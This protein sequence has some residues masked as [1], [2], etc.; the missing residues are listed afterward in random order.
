[1]LDLSSL[2]KALAAFRAALEFFDGVGRNSAEEEREL[3]RDGVIQRF[4]FTYELSW[5]MMKRYLDVYG[6]EKA[7]GLSNKELFRVA[8]EQGL[9]DAPERWFHYL[10]MRNQTSYIYDRQKA[11]E[12]F[13]AAR[14]F[15]GDCAQLLQRLREK[16]K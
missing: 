14:E 13:S 8:R 5:K 16:T 2:E 6:L 12:V 15:L 11:S 9:I 1:M 3:L 4:E 7:D 10:K